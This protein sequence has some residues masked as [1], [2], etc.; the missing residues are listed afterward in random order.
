MNDAKKYQRIAA[1]CYAV[2]TLVSDPE[3]KRGMLAIAQ[4]WL[5]L[6]E[7]AERNSHVQVAQETP[8]CDD[9]GSAPWPRSL[10]RE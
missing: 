10:N 2:A 9:S 3:S 1:D 5:L 8:L 6:A 7:Q 4:A